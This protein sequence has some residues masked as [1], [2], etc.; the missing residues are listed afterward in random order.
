[1]PEKSNVKEVCGNCAYND[2]GLCDKLG[3]FVEDDDDCMCG[4]KSGF[5]QRDK[6]VKK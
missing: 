6:K 4:N 2:S 3:Y 5:E 1:M